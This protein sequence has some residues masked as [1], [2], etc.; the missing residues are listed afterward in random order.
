MIANSETDATQLQDSESETRARQ[1]STGGGQ[2]PSQ[3]AGYRILR[4]LGE[5]KYGAVWLARE[6]NTGKHV[7]IKFYTHRRGV[8]WSLLGR[9]VEKLAVLYTSRNVV[10]L[11]A[12]GWDHDPP[13]YVMEYLENGSLA[14]RL[15]HG[16]LPVAEAVRLARE[17]CHGLVHAHGSG[18]LHC[19]LKPANILLGQ[20]DEP[21]LCDFGQSRLADEQQHALGTLFYMAPEQADLKA[22]PDAKWDVYALGAIL[23]H[24]LTGSPPFRTPEAEARLRAAGTLED[25]LAVY[26]DIVRDAPRPEAHRRRR[27]VDSRLADLVDQCLSRNPEKRL[28]NA[29]IALDLFEARERSRSRR[30]LLLSALILP[31]AILAFLVPIALD[32]MTDA[33]QTTRTNLTDRALESDVLSA[34]LLAGSLQRELENRLSDLQRVAEN[35]VLR[36]LVVQRATLPV[37]QRGPLWEFLDRQVEE[38]VRHQESHERLADASWFLCDAQGFQRWRL[39]RSNNSLD[40]D[41]NHRDYFN[42]LD[43]ELDEDDVSKRLPPITKGHISTAYQSTSTGRFSLALSVPVREPGGDRIV[44]VLARTLWLSELLSDYENM[45]VPDDLA[46]VK[47]TLAIVDSRNGRLIAHPW[48]ETKEFHEIEEASRR[49]SGVIR[50]SGRIAERLKGLMVTKPEEAAARRWD[51]LTDYVDPVGERSSEYA[52]IWLAALR[53]VEGTRWVAIVQ[54]QRADVWLPVENLQSRLR[55]SGLAAIGLIAALMVASWALL[56]IQL[57]YKDRGK[58]SRWY[59]RL[60]ERAGLREEQGATSV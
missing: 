55:W 23:Y 38:K 51:R 31:L 18:I 40:H 56:A 1:L 44:G 22:V 57:R 52:G 35:P 17:V 45:V 39:P 34:S 30:P 41:Y 50:M 5:G 32:A 13:Y 10:G 3:V 59:N 42:G 43:R 33:V 7:A 11:Q 26:Q 47:R 58:T 8:D 25:R 2:P 14:G 15:E 60:A 20:D 19:D 29:Q 9:E 27:G 48:L 46:T 28:A 24:M 21:R 12:V 36:E 53:R 37:D 6:Q 49:T 4:P 16:P 54:E